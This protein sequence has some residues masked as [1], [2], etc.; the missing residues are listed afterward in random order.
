[1]T[2]YRVPLFELLRRRLGEE[3]VRLSV[4]YGS[5]A[6][7]ELMRG[8]EAVLPWGVQVPTR[9][10][11]LPLGEAFYQPLPRALLDRQD[12]IVLPHENR[13]LHNYA[14]L[15]RRRLGRG[16]LAFWG[17]GANFQAGRAGGRRE[18]FK[19]WSTRLVDWWFAYTEASVERVAANGFPK[20]RITCLDNAVDTR[21]LVAWR[22]GVAPDELEALRRRLGLGHEV[23]VFIGSLHEA[24]RMG[25]LFDAA[26]RLRER[27]PGFE[28]L[29]R[30]ARRC[31]L[32]A[33][34]IRG[35]DGSA[36]SMGATRSCTWPSRG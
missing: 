13:L 36:R 22:D 10:I 21:Q 2:Q 5:P 11:R 26:K 15:A 31:G 9:H 18:A 28:L 7:S 12:L 8:D 20:E 35:R 27:I 33:R 24:R 19:A 17:H 25:F 14:L 30:C 3:G 4:A 16:R 29:E 32:S 6:K 23:A 34:R 1:M